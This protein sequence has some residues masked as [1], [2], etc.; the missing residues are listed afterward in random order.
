MNFTREILE[1]Y[2]KVQEMI[3]L[4]I[5]AIK[6][7]KEY[8]KNKEKIKFLLLK[9]KTRKYFKWQKSMDIIGLIFLKLLKEEIVNKQE[10]DIQ[11]NLIKIQISKNGQMKKIIYQSKVTKNTETNGHQQPNYLM[12][13]PKIW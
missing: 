3:K 6:D 13:E 7:T 8:L 2:P 12:V 1:K 5:L 11:I 4:I 10:I 9:V